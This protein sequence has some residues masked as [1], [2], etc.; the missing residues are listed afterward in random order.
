MGVKKLLYEKH[1]CSSKGTGQ[2]GPELVLF[3]CL[4]AGS[5]KQPKGPYFPE[6][7]AS[8]KIPN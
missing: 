1:H 3:N 6:K 8:D 4:I 2:T 7:Y 5:P